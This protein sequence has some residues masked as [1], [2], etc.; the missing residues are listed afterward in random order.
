MA[1]AKQAADRVGGQSILSGVSPLHA[2]VSQEVQS[3]VSSNPQAA[4]RVFGKRADG[5]ANKALPCSQRGKAAPVEAAPARP[6]SAD[7]DTPIVVLKDRT[8]VVA[9]QSFAGGDRD[10]SAIEELIQ[11][12]LCSHPEIAF[13][14]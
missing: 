13:A 3:G 12:V 11:P 2:T 6:E 10:R 9:R 1:V 5:V 14:I 7:P 4:C 8:S